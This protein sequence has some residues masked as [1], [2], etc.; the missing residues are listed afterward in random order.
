M[1]CDNWLSARTAGEDWLQN[2]EVVHHRARDGNLYAD[3]G[4]LGRDEW[5]DCLAFCLANP[6]RDAVSC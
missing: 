4:F 1:L 6:V 3:R 5:L 2:L